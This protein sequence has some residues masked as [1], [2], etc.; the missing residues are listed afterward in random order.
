MT[1]SRTAPIHRA[2]GVLALGVALALA[3]CGG[4]SGGDASEPAA[5]DPATTAAQGES[6]DKVDIAEFSFKP[7]AITVAKGTTV[8]WTNQDNFAHTVKGNVGSFAESPSLDK[9]AAFTHKFDEAGS[10]P[11]I[12]GI[13]NSMSGTVT[14][15]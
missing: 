1:S 8:T 13:H 10:F 15:S 3:G 12:C 5:D 9:G 2:F 6:T 14:V 4:S 11:Y 7:G